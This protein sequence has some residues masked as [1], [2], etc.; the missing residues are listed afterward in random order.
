MTL[1]IINNE[2][3]DKISDGYVR[4]IGN[5]YLDAC[6]GQIEFAGGGEAAEAWTQN[7][8]GLLLYTGAC[9]IGKTHF[10][11]AIIRYAVSKGLTN[12]RYTSEQM[13]FSRLRRAIGDSNNIDYID[14]IRHIADQQLFILDDF[15][16]SGHTPFREEVMLSLIDYRLN[17]GKRYATL[18]TTNLTREAIYEDWSQLSLSGTPRTGDRS[19]IIKDS[20]NKKSHPRIG[21][22]LFAKTNV[23]WE[24]PDH[25]SYR[26]Q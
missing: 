8:S 20:I 16:A 4:E 10:C 12:L 19:E 22:R 24:A 6:L 26:Q 9:G 11:A 7:P 25:P 21:D 17:L 15:G 18:I 2:S 23:I 5:I 14:L 3:L 1:Q 13:F